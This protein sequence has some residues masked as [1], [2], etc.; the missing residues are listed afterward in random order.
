MTVTLTRVST[1]AHSHTRSI[2]FVAEALV[3]GVIK[4]AQEYGVCEKNWADRLELL[5]RGPRTWLLMDQLKSVIVEIF[6]GDKLVNKYEFPIAVNAPSHDK[7]SFQDH[8]DK[9]ME[10]V[11]REAAKVKATHYRFLCDCKPG[12]VEVPGWSSA[13][14]A[15]DSHLKKRTIHDSV[16]RT[17][18]VRV[19]ATIYTQRDPGNGYVG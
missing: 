4:I 3:R 1:S 15:D 9:I 14:F 5:L 19:E 8:F 10:Q 18:S 11:R 6:C 7:E 16:V 2:T 12:R 13:Y 17:N